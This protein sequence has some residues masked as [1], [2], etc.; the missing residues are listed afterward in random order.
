MSAGHT[1]AAAAR[2]QAL[3]GPVDA[4]RDELLRIVDC[5]VRE[6]AQGA[7]AAGHAPPPDAHAM[8]SRMR[9]LINEF[10]S[11]E[12]IK[13]IELAIALEDAD[14]RSN[15]FDSLLENGGEL[16]DLQSLDLEQADID[17]H[18]NL[19]LLLEA[20]RALPPSIRPVPEAMR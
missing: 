15:H 19:N 11:Y 12:R 8:H 18:V 9:G 7:A 2:F 14:R 3:A 4:F 5:L 17:Y 6:Y 16:T 10:R 20:V 13:I 1:D